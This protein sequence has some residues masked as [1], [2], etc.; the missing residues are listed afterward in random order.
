MRIEGSYLCL[1]ETFPGRDALGEEQ[2]FAM[3]EE[4]NQ[5]QIKLW[6]FTWKT[7]LLNISET[8]LVVGE[9]IQVNLIVRKQ[10]NAM[11]YNAMQ[12]NAM[13]EI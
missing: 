13:E 7:S 3:Q 5:I 2:D 4:E 10:Y 6:H 11:Q 8:R 1:F 9:A 12:Y